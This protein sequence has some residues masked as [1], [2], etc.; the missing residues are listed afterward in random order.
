LNFSLNVS[1]SLI[2]LQY[3]FTTQAEIV[4]KYDRQ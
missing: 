3:N 4:L 1:C 2:V